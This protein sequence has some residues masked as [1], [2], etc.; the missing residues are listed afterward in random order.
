MCP[1]TVDLLHW[2]KDM[3]P[4]ISHGARARSSGTMGNVFPTYRDAPQRVFGASLCMKG[5]LDFPAYGRG[6]WR[7]PGA[8]LSKTGKPSGCS[9]CLRNPTWHSNSWG[10]QDQA[11]SCPRSACL[12][13]L[14]SMDRSGLTILSFYKSNR[15]MAQI[16]PTY[17][18]AANLGYLWYDKGYRCLF[19]WPM[20]H[21][22]HF[23]GS[24][25]ATAASARR[26]CK[27]EHCNASLVGLWLLYCG[28]HM[29]RKCL[30][31]L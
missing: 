29:V 24:T 16:A 27:A 12:G 10:M 4:V 17:G 28:I 11:P 9:R 19:A 5:S 3:F 6:P 26:D 13:W 15:E 25:K 31:S 23:Y 1:A 18:M 30:S 14:K 8:H 7:L 22:K 2:A 20:C 21:H